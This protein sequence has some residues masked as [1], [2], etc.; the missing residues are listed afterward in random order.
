MSH[1]KDDGNMAEMRR[2]YIYSPTD[3]LVD[4]KDVETHAAEAETKGFSVALEKFEGSAHVAHLRKD[5]SR[6]WEIVKRTLEG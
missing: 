6:Y 1:N 2:V 4:Y 3:A 5:E